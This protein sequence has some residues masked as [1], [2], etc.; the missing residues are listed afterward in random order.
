MLSMEYQPLFEELEQRANPAIAA[1]MSAYMRDL[2][3]FLG[4][5]S[6]QLDA[7]SK[8][9]LKE[10]VRISEVDWDF[11]LAC[12]E[13]P[14]RE[15][16]YIAV[17]YLVKSTPKMEEGDL[18]RLK[19]FVVKKSWWD[20]VDALSKVAGTLVMRFPG[21]TPVMLEWSQDDNI[22]LRRVAILHQ[23]MFKEKTDT[24][25]L[26]KILVSNFGTGEFFIDKAM[27]WILR[28]YSKTNPEWVRS[29]IH[30]YQSRMS[31]LTLRES[32][33]YI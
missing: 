19:M 2:F 26:E 20:T 11:V 32:R 5:P 21:L 15:A 8:T 18:Q 1:Q 31:K 3:L 30:Q 13:K 33:K 12:W 29:F 25:L 16:Q 7:I 22:W 4:L 27:G 23:L 14:Y 10:F 9:Y 28:Q 6:P 17:D 24:V